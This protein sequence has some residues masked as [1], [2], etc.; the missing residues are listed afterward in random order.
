MYGS[1]AALITGVDAAIA[2]GIGALIGSGGK[3][4]LALSILATA[5]VAAVGFQPIRA[6]L[7]RVVN[8]LV[9]NG[10][11]GH[12]VYEVLSRFSGQV[13]ETYAADDVL[14]RMARVL[15]A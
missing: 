10:Q 4:N 15:W 13:A 12:P 3:P 5:I 6:R 2:V 14:P 8:R 1:L 7:Q 11:A 9:G